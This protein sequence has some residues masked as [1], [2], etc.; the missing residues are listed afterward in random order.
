MWDFWKSSTFWL[1][2]AAIILPFGWLPF[3]Y[4]LQ[5]VRMRAR[6]FRRS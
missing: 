3:A 6:Y 5:P 1:T 4:K 2:L